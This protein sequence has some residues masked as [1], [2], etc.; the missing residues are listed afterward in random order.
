MQSL[1]TVPSTRFSTYG[2]IESV[3]NAVPGTVPLEAG[4][5]VTR[6][7]IVV[8]AGRGKSLQEWS[9]SW[10]LTR[11]ERIGHRAPRKLEG[12]GL[13]D[14]STDVRAG[15]GSVHGRQCKRPRSGKRR[16]RHHAW[17]AR[18]PPY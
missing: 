18:V 14:S 5:S 13:G 6:V 3:R 9:I 17:I 1:P 8:Y 12:R 4:Q 7:E 2:T 11:L 10:C 16:Y 15:F